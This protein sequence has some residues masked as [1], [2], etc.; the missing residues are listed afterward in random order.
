[1]KT[2]KEF[3]MKYVVILFSFSL[4][5]CT[6][7]GQEVVDSLP[8]FKNA[9]LVNKFLDKKLN[10]FVCKKAKVMLEDADMKNYISYTLLNTGIMRNLNGFA[11]YYSDSFFLVV[12]VRGIV[13]FKNRNKSKSWY[14]KKLCQRKI[15]AID[16][17]LHLL[18]NKQ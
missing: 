16:I 3:C 17:P 18:I 13:Q 10:Q 15:I 1:M 11:L 9:L 8:G 2:H 12:E 4:L 5:S 6:I 14:F 7:F